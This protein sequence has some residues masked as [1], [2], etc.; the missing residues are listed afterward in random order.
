[1]AA[2]FDGVMFVVIFFCLPETWYVRHS[3]DMIAPRIK[4]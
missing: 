4:Q 2:I 1:M 3:R